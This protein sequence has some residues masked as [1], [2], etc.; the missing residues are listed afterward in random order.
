[1]TREWAALAA[2]MLAYA[3]LFVAYYPPLPGIE[4]EIGF[5][6]Q[7]LVW[8]RGAISAEGAGL[9]DL[10]DFVP[11]AGR[12]V[13]ARHPGRSHAGSAWRAMRIGC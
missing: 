11:V 7:A 4:D 9:S 3:A 1:M 8:S 13:A 2:L 5:V 6:N 12:H 10:A